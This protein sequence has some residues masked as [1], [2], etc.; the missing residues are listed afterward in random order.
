MNRCTLQEQAL[1]C[2]R[3][4]NCTCARQSASSL[5]TCPRVCA[6]VQ[7]H[8]WPSPE[9]DEPVLEYVEPSNGYVVVDGVKNELD[10]QGMPPLTPRQIAILAA[11]ANTEAQVQDPFQ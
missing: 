8:S 10:L 6:G 2:P 9:S 11:N 3:N 5:V 1:L 7:I 4:T